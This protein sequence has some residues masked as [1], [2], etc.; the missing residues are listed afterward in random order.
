M[1][2]YIIIRGALGIGKSTIARK[3]SRILNAGYISI[4][5]VLEENGLDKVEPDAECIPA[6]NFIL[7]DEIILPEVKGKNPL[8]KALQKL[9]II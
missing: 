9:F 4:D 3:L 1:S 8:E 2:Y 5:K 6:K 7:A